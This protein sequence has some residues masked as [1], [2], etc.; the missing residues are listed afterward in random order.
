MADTRHPRWRY[1]VRSVGRH[2]P[3]ARSA[4][5]RPPIGPY[6]PA[7][8]LRPGNGQ[9]NLVDSGLRGL[10][11]L[12]SLS[13]E[14]VATNSPTPGG[15]GQVAVPRPGRIRSGRLTLAAILI[16]QAALSLHLVWSNT[17]YTDE[18]L[19][20]WAGHLEWTHWLHGI[21]LPFFPTYFSGAPVIYPPLGAL[22]DSIGGL[23]GA[24][25]LSLCFMLGAT[26]LL[27]ST[28]SRLYGREAAFFASALWAFLGPTL[29]LG[30][31][32]TFDAMSLFLVTLAVWCATAHH[33]RDEATGW[34]VAGAVAL[35]LANAAKYASTIFDPAVILLAMLAVWPHAGG[36]A[37][38]RRGV[39]L[40]TCVF[41]IL[42]LAIRFS[43]PYY[44]TGISDTTLTRTSGTDSASTVLSHAGVWVGPVF[45]LACVGVALS[46]IRRVDRHCALLLAVLACTALLAPLAQARIHTL[47]S[48][49]KHAD[50]GAWFAAIAAGYA[51]D[52]AAVK[53]RPVAVRAAAMAAAGAAITAI[54]I[55]G[56]AQAQDLIA[57]WPSASGFVN[58]LRPI[59]TRTQGPILVEVSPLGEYYLRSGSQWKRWSNTYGIQL[60]SG[61]TAGYSPH[62]V[63]TAGIP[64]AYAKFISRGY[65][66]IIVLNSGATPT[67]DHD[68]EVDLARTPAY[69]IIGWFSYGGTVYPVWAHKDTR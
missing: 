59:V 68:I 38:L 9:D 18:A 40:T 36:K 21:R 33:T 37:A 23:A 65:F 54:A 46:V 16:A 6:Q 12:M 7:P 56:F 45:A 51:I 25:M 20:L 14:K 57:S 34:M 11:M 55:A 27:W 3:G 26:T 47:T 41:G 22:A 63:N 1:Q 62:Q 49:D 13:T 28:T 44:K 5:P 24:R 19:Y 4:M 8:P 15:T 43:G 32:A 48:L 61:A 69:H 10:E 35:A 31:F 58:A 52:K 64:A 60:M 66:S 29:M 17:A 42:Y 39:L 2:G 53:L 67:L 50:F 30:A